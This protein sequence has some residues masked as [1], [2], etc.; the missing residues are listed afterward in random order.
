MIANFNTLLFTPNTPVF[1]TSTPETTQESIAQQV[2]VQDQPSV[3]PAQPAQPRFK[4]VAGKE[5]S[6]APESL[7]PSESMSSDHPDL[8]DGGTPSGDGGPRPDGSS[9]IGF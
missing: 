8:P 5:V 7:V 9:P 3:F 2:F 6:T 1:T 4:C